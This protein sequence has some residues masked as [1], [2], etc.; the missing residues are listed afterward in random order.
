M[1]HPSIQKSRAQRRE[2]VEYLKQHTR[3]RPD[4]LI[5]LGTGLGPLADDIEAETV[6][7]YADIP[8]FAEATI[9]E[10]AGKLIFGKLGDKEVAAM[11]GRF[12]F[13]E[14]Y[15]MQQVV[16]PIRVLKELSAQTLFVSNA[17][18]GMNP[19]FSRGDIMLIT[20]HINFMGYNPLIGPND[21]EL[22][23]RFPDMSE[24]YTERL[25]ELA[26]TVALEESIKLHQGVY[27]GVSGPTL[28][29]KAEYRFMRLLGA[30]AVGMSTIPEVIAA[31]HMG[32]DVLGIS[33]VTDECFPDALEPVYLEDVIEAAGIA[34]PKIAHL[35][36]SILKKL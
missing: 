6:I 29:T 22:G 9:N 16:F 27:M 26:E 8:H 28:E 5:V 18:G 35:F 34:A 24:P 31:V 36:N 15:T 10:H 3:L 19:N 25:L 14:G 17:C 13:Y 23:P 11:Q 32:M 20:D 12:H 21:E 4:Y 7:P 30:D 33:A 2:A 1:S